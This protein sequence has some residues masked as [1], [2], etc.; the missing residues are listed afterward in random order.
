M[1][2]DNTLYKKAMED[3]T[4]YKKDR[5]LKTVVNNRDY[6]VVTTLS[7]FRIRYVMHRD[8]LQKLNPEVMIDDLSSWGCTAVINEDVEEFSQQCFREVITDVD[9]LTEDEMLELFD[10]DNDYL[11][12]WTREYKIEWVRKNLKGEDSHD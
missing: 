12:D 9:T 2:K 7:Q 11:K 1:N 5:L 4:L 3:N 10:K 8:D 6:A